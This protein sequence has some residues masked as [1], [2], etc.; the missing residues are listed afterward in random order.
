VAVF[1]TKMALMTGLILLAIVSLTAY[2]NYTETKAWVF[3][4]D[5]YVT[6][7]EYVIP[8]THEELAK[9]PTVK[10]Y[11]DYIDSNPGIMP[12]KSMSIDPFEA[13]LLVFFLS[14]RASYDMKPETGS[15][16]GELYSFSINVAGRDYG[17]NIV[18][19]NQRPILD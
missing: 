1:P 13:R 19:S 4:S 8:I 3:G 17:V 9:Y 11:I 6:N 15:S 10:A 5:L 18:F 2:T 16:M 7:P 12:F 14:Q